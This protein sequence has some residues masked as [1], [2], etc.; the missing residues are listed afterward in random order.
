LASVHRKLETAA[1]A[2]IIVVAIA[3]IWVVATR[4]V[5]RNEAKV[6]PGRRQREAAALRPGT[7][8]ALSPVDWRANRRT[9]ILALMSDCLS[10]TESAPFHRSVVARA[11]EKGLPLIA[12]LPEARAQ[13]EAYVRKMELEISDVRQADMKALSIG[14]VPAVIVVDGQ[15]TVERAW[16]GRLGPAQQEDVLRTISQE[17][18]PGG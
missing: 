15:G 17:S 2:A 11:R 12:L 1:N 6:D 4:F 3:I 18:R 13:G 14:R 5:G 9:V 7:S 16:L 10:C 8:M